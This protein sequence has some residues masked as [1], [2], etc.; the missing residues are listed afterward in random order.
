MC[1]RL[2]LI[3][4]VMDAVPSADAGAPGV[5]DSGKGGCALVDRG[6][7]FHGAHVVRGEE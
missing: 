2:E 5:R 6:I 3:A 1:D 4:R 7:V